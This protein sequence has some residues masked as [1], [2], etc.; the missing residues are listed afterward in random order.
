MIPD[1][2]GGRLLHVQ[3]A[4]KAVWISWGAGPNQMHKYA[5]GAMCYACLYV[6]HGCTARI[7]ANAYK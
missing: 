5:C 1:E 7:H 4:S 3:P 6:L 2:G